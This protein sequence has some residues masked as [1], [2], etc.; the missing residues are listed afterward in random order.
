[1]K[2]CD[3]FKQKF[4]E[5]YY[6]EL[7]GEEE[8]ELKQHFQTCPDCLKAYEE[9]ENILTALPPDTVAKIPDIR[10]ERIKNRIQSEIGIST[11]QTR[12]F[13]LRRWMPTMASAAIVLLVGALTFHFLPTNNSFRG[14]MTA[15]EE[16]E[17]AE[18]LDLLENLEL[19]EI[20]EALEEILQP[21]EAEPERGG[22]L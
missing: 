20:L 15:E 8:N 6:G 12:T 13:P 7:G 5:H 21:H 18:N 22:V 4:A 17:V 16:L 9:I 2:R 11:T 3:D 14:E 19:I 10:K 1:M